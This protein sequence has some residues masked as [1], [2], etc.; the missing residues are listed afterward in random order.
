MR[1]GQ[2]ARRTGVSVRMLRYYEVEGLLNP[3]RTDSGQRDYGPGDEDT[4]RRIRALG[5]AGMTLSVI[6]DFLPCALDDRGAFEPCDELK[7][8]LREQM[9]KVDRQ[10]SALKRSRI[11]LSEI[12]SQ[13][14]RGSSS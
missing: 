9:V 6:R 2:L 12:Q 13:L 8:V 7:A 4:I 5:A 14:S 10:I 11:V 1:I 3:P